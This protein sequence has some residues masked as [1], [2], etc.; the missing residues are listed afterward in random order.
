[1]QVRVEPEFHLKV[2]KEI[3]EIINDSNGVGKI[4]NKVVD[5]IAKS[6]QFD[7]VSVYLWD[8]TKEELVLKAC[9]GLTYDDSHQIRLKPNE[10]LTGMVYQDKKVHNIVPASRH[11]R[12][13]FFPDLGESSYESYLGAPILSDEKCLGVLVAQHQDENGF[14]SSCSTMFEIIADRLSN[15]FEVAGKIDEL[16]TF[17]NSSIGERF[18]QGSGVSSGIV[19]GE[20]ISLGTLVSDH[21]ISQL[22]YAGLENEKNRLIDAIDSVKENQSELIDY[23]NSDSKLS[24][25]EIKIFKSQQMF[26]DDPE[27]LKLIEKNIDVGKMPAERAL[28]TALKEF[29]EQFGTEIPEFF[30]DRLNDF[31]E[32]MDKVISE[33]LVQRDEQGADL[34]VPDGAIIIAHEIGPGRLLSIIKKDIKA[35]VT[36]IGGE[37]GHMVIIA[38]SMGIPVVTNIPDVEQLIKSKSK[39]L[40]DGRTGFVFL[41]PTESLITEY[42]LNNRKRNEIKTKIKEDAKDTTESEINI[43]LSANI[44]F[45]GDIGIA[46]EVGLTNVGLFRTEF[47]FMQRRSWPDI[48]EQVEM[49]SRV[50]TSFDGYVTVRT[51]DI[52]SDKI[53]SYH[54]FKREDNP[55]LGMRSIRFSMENLDLFE[56]QIAAIIKTMQAGYHL[57]ILLPMITRSWELEVAND[58][59]LKICNKLG[60][61]RDETPTLG[62]MIEVPGVVY[63]LEDYLELVDFISLGTNDL[64]QYLLAIDR[65]NAS[66]GHM[67]CEYHPI[68]IRFLDDVINRVMALNKDITV[69]GEMGGNPMGLLILLALGYRKI[70]VTPERAYLVSYITKRI[71]QAK[72]DILRK[73]ILTEKKSSNIR[74]ILRQQLESI[75]PILLDLD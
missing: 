4:L 27:V 44:G 24:N 34:D 21:D 32:I 30:K 70:S 36:E 22:E 65:N 75:D 39:L 67:Y 19:Y 55:M 68:V 1:M 29:S 54:K 71:S 69:C 58:T 17:S 41:N 12:Y 51:L 20:T 10:G 6:L 15:V 38:K 66:V 8:P 28:K 48:D 62:M 52:G 61:N 40:V 35:I 11:H 14:N 73:Q 9:H 45:P 46:K 33:L 64:I 72:L 31:K 3:G 2:V 63:Q 18:W 59:L 16:T 47:S 13:K 25:A 5:H 26:L 43:D 37:A 23:L 74:V 7:V 57:R 49:Y 53:L 60:L 50:A 42:E 56:I